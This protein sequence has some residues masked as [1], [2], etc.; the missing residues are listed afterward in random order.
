MLMRGI[1]RKNN[2]QEEGGMFFITCFC[3]VAKDDFGWLDIG[4]S[5]TFGYYDSFEEADKMVKKNHCDMHETIYHYAV[6]EHVGIGIHSRRKGRWFYKYDKTKGEFLPIKEPEEFKH[7][8]N[9]ALG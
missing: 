7:C 5:R 4:D 6:I 2:P 8:Y 1:E 9:I 3:K